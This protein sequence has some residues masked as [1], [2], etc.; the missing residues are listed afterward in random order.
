MKSEI[1][2][3]KLLKYASKG[4]ELWSPIFGK[5][6]LDKVFSNGNINIQFI[7]EGSL[8]SR[9]FDCYGHYCITSALHSNNKGTCLLFPSENHC[10]WTD[11][12]LSKKHKEFK[13]GQQVLIFPNSLKPIWRLCLYSHWN[14]ELET[15]VTI[16][17][18]TYEDDKILP[19]EGNENLLGKE[20]QTLL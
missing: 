1:N 5:C 17:G 2:I 9:M 16:T 20:V 18:N 6:F 8:K 15:H 7:F 3:A 13:P 4:T 10:T 19:Y 14:Q 11:F 12:K